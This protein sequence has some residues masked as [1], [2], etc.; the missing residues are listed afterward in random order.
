MDELNISLKEA[1]FGLSKGIVNTDRQRFFVEQQLFN[2]TILNQ[3]V[4]FHWN[5]N[6][7]I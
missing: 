1:K 5:L 3:I 2:N 6:I 7:V 4:Q